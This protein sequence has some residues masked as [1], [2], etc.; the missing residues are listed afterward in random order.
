MLA[1]MVSVS[2]VSE[3]AFAQSAVNASVSTAPT[4]PTATAPVSAPAVETA[5]PA[6]ATANSGDQQWQQELAVWQAAM[7]GNTPGDYKAYLAAY[8]NG[9]FA[10]MAKN[11][12][13]E[14]A[15]AVAPAPVEVSRPSEPPPPPPPGFTVG[16]PA[17]EAVFLDRGTKREVQGRLTSI[18]YPTGG[19]DGSFGERTRT[20]ISRWQA[21]VGAPVT[22]YLSF[23]QL[24]RL[25]QDSAGVYEDWLNQQVAVRRHVPR[26][27]VLEGRVKDNHDDAA[28]ALALGLIG[29]AL[30]GGAIAAGGGHGHGGPRFMPGHG[31]RRHP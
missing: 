16:T 30:L 3:T 8:P 21:V 15:P 11:R 4:A 10:A 13:A 7:A 29:G 1:G 28:A 25:R 31:P 19:A 14:A 20:A 6:A 18:G 23:D 2:L 27:P 12:I 9:K 17:T 26:G 24:M 5:A 22:G